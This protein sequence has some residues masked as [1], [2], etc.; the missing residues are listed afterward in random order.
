MTTPFL[1]PWVDKG[2]HSYSK[3]EVLKDHFT[4]KAEDSQTFFS[5]LTLPLNIELQTNTHF[6]IV[7]ET[8]NELRVPGYRSQPLLRVMSLRLR[9]AT[10]VTLGT[11]IP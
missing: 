2:K 7:V 8:L 10:K 4:S 9:T 3:I 1:M 5:S 11:W 6:F